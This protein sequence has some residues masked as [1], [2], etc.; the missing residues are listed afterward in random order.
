LLPRWE[1]EVR[2]FDQDDL[3]SKVQGQEYQVCL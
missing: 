2:S 1:G 3:I